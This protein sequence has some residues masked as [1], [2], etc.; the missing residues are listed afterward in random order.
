MGEIDWASLKKNA[1]DATKPAPPGRYRLFCDKADAK[2]ASTGS[3]M[4]STKFHI[5]GGP[6]HGKAIFH[7]F[8]LT[9]D[10]AFALSIFFR[11]LAAFGLDDNFFAQMNSSSLEP[12]ALALVGRQADADIDIRPYQGTDRN[13]INGFHPVSGMSAA[14][15]PGNPTPNM[16]PV[17]S[18]T[19]PTPS[20][21]PPM[22]T[23]TIPTPTIAPSVLVKEEA[24]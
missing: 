19:A 12:V 24:F 21:A 15:V 11:G 22:P 5:E 3:L 10:N 7:N 6:L 2:T 23:M 20:S 14:V 1:D 13:Q 17:P 18:M 4:I 9:V 8:V 16:S